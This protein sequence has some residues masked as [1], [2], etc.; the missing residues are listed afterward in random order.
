MVKGVL[1]APLLVGGVSASLVVGE[2]AARLYYLFAGSSEHLQLSVD[3][4][5]LVEPKP[6]ITYRSRSG[7][8]V[9]VNRLGLKGEEFHPRKPNEVRVLAAGDSIMAGEYLREEERLPNLLARRIAR[10]TGKEVH[11]WNTAVGGYNAR[12]TLGILETKVRKVDPDIVLIGVCAN[13][14][15]SFRYRAYQMGNRLFVRGRDG[16]VARHLN[17]LYQRSDLFKWLY[18]QLHKIFMMRR[19]YLAYLQHRFPP[20]DTAS[21]ERWEEALDRMAQISK[22][23]Q[24]V[25][26]F[27]FFPLHSQVYRGER[28]V[29]QRLVAWAEKR[30]HLFL[31]PTPIFRKEDA[32]GMSFYLERDIVH[33]NA[34]AFHRVSDALYELIQSAQLAGRLN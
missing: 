28:A 23:V 8:T 30:G 7:Q 20:A 4:E 26:L 13:D 29:D 25:P 34:K 24:A 19:G 31:D 1:R 2:G 6:S 10:E 17:F 11:V 18:D 32:T 27:V 22:E 16:S 21:L 33:P 3:P 9:H 5:V 14:Y 15:V 12:Q